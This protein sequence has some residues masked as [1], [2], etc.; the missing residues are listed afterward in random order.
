MSASMLLNSICIKN[1]IASCK[2]RLNPQYRQNFSVGI[3][4]DFSTLT[5]FNLIVSTLLSDLMD[6]Y[7]IRD[8]SCGSK[9]N[10]ALVQLCACKAAANRSYVYVSEKK[11]KILPIPEIMQCIS[12][13]AES[14]EERSKKTSFPYQL[15][16]PI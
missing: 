16:A 7:T 15:N 5:D 13:R 4:Q 8:S 9:S 2:P 3:F 1:M 14:K 12:T 10:W 11:I 6:T